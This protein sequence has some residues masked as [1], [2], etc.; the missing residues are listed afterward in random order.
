MAVSESISV[1]HIIPLLP[2]L[3]GRNKAGDAH[4]PSDISLLRPDF[5]V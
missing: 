1:S 5:G 2:T 4:I 3:D